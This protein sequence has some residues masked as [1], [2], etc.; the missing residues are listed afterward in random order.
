MKWNDEEYTTGKPVSIYITFVFENIFGP[1]QIKKKKFCTKFMKQHADNLK[2]LYK[3]KDRLKF[4]PDK[5]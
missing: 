3:K 5:L 1:N 2:F 4:Q